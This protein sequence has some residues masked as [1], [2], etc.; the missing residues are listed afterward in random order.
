MNFHLSELLGKIKINSSIK[1][2]DLSLVQ[3]NQYIAHRLL[4]I[5]HAHSIHPLAGQGFNLTMRGIETIYQ[6]ASGLNKKD[7]IGNFKKFKY[8]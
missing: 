7:E 1:S 3:S 5:D 4:L 8:I 6:M 2:W